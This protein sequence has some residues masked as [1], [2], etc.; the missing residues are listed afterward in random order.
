MIAVI[1]L[2][3]GEQAIFESMGEKIVAYVAMACQLAWVLLSFVAIDKE[4]KWWSRTWPIIVLYPVPPAPAHTA[5]DKSMMFAM[6]KP[7]TA[8]QRRRNFP[9]ASF[10]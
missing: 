8:R 4:W 2:L 9:S 7:A 6:A 1:F 3:H 10:S 5:T